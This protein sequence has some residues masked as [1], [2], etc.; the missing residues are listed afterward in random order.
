MKVSHPETGENFEQ[1]LHYEFVKLNEK[2]ILSEGTLQKRNA[3]TQEKNG[4]IAGRGE[5]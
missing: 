2:Q 3:R 5:I 1:S 4:K